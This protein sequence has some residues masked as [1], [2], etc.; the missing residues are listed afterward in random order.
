MLLK[1]SKHNPMTVTAKSFL[2]KQ[3]IIAITYQPRGNKKGEV[4]SSES[5]FTKEQMCDSK[6]LC[7]GT[8]KIVREHVEDLELF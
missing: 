2:L 3:F 7:S 8:L 6:Q 1:G 5:S 4:D